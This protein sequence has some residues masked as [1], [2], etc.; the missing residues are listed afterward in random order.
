MEK[1]FYVKSPNKVSINLTDKAINITRKGF[2]NLMNQGLKGDKTIPLKNITAVQLKKPGM[3]SGYIQFGV[4]GGN[5]SKG[6][7]FAA[8][9][10]EN[11]IMFSKKH[12]NDM[13]ELKG[14]IEEY[15]FRDEGS[16][17][18]VNAHSGKS[19][20]EQVKELKEL[21]DMDIIT[22]DEFDR[23]KNELLNL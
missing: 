13:V 9:Q 12:Y 3:T 18:I 15:I 7:V 23:K 2:V 4:L 16:T 10:D 11:T 20:A 8:T 5:E 17:T 21:L 6:G 1:E 14:Y 22:K 19:A